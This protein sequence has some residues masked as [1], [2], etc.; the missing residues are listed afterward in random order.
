MQTAFPPLSRVFAA[1]IAVTGLAMVVLQVAINTSSEVSALMALVHMLRFFTLWTNFGGALMFAWLAA[2]RPLTARVL[3]ALATAYAVVALVYHGLLAATHH[4][5]GLDWWTNLM[6]HSL[7]PAA[8]IAWWFAFAPRIEWRHLP[9]VMIAP[10]IYTL[11]ALVV[12]KTT[13]FY[14]YFFLDQPKLGWPGFFA[15]LV[16]LAL[17]FV[18]MAAVLKGCRA[19][20]SHKRL[21]TADRS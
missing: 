3:L 17:F 10:V 14:P 6:F 11:F 13:A 8:A 18:A 12:G 19:V 4:P 7:L 20:L 2:G 1:A 5:V 9:F 15:W 16:A 21:D